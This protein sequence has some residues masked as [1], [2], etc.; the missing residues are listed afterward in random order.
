QK[1]KRD[2]Y[3]LSVFR[4]PNGAVFING[5]SINDPQSTQMVYDRLKETHNLHSK[6]LTLV[7]NNRRDRAYRTEHMI[8]LV[9]SITP[10]RVWLLGAAQGA[11]KNR[12]LKQNKDLKVRQIKDIKELD[13][14]QLGGDEVLFAVGNIANEGHLLMEKVKEEAVQIE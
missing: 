11:V 3:D 6:N 12:L 2:P 5:M 7:V 13:F 10:S 14:K 4:F 9:A 8:S 1:F